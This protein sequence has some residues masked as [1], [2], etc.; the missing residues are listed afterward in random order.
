[1]TQKF[2]LFKSN[3]PSTRGGSVFSDNGKGISAITLQANNLSYMAADKGSITMY[4]NASAPFEENSL[5]LAGESFEKTSITVTCEVGREVELMEA[6]I[7]FVNRDKTKNVMKFDSIGGTNTFSKISPSPIIDTRVRARPVERGLVG[8]DAIVTGLDANAVVNS[9]DFL[10][11]GN[12]PFI[13]FAGEN[14]SVNDGVAISSFPNSGISGADYDATGSTTSGHPKPF[15]KEP[16]SACSQKT[17]CFDLTGSLKVGVDLSNSGAASHI[18]GNVNLDANLS[19]QAS[20]AIIIQRGGSAISLGEDPT[21]T[22]S[23]DASSNVTDFKV[24]NGGRG[25]ES[26]DVFS[27]GFESNGLVTYT[28]QSNEFNY[29]FYHSTI[30]FVTVPTSPDVPFPLID[31]VIYV[32]F[33]APDGALFNPLYSNNIGVNS[34]TE[35]FVSNMGPMP[36]SSLGNEFE[37]NHGQRVVAADLSVAYT[38]SIQSQAFP[39]LSPGFEYRADIGD[40]LSS[41]KNLYT[42]L[43][44]RTASREVFIYSRDGELISSRGPNENDDDTKLELRQFGMVLPF[45]VS[46]P[47]IRIARFG[48]VEKDLGDLL[49]RNIAVQL[50]N[51]YT[52]TRS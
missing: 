9:I 4:F 5:T 3:D 43:I 40:E 49:C 27:I 19:D 15:C 21:F 47:Q 18:V 13:D 36:G 20:G 1:M 31:Y 38:T 25:I 50:Q 10:K 7:N 39:S 24:V 48:I 11:T 44:R 26:G 37:V 17:V 46:N 41:E 23:T 12:K 45:N 32:T 33:V 30:D 2:F 51:H 14:I 22:V 8:S 6:I 28:V 34:F 29:D 52:T 35:T 42:F 16:D